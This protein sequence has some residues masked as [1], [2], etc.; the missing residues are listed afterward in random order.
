[1]T[2]VKAAAPRPP[3][4]PISSAWWLGQATRVA[5]KLANSK[6]WLLVDFIAVS[7]PFG[8]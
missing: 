7:A 5:G 6:A 3:L 1:M 2:D 4:A 8:G